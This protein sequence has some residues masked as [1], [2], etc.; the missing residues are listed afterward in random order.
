[1][2]RGRGER[3]REL[4]K[5]LKMGKRENAKGRG[6]QSSIDTTKR[7]QLEKK[8]ER[9]FNREKERKSE[10]ERERKKGRDKEKER[11]RELEGGRGRGVKKKDQGTVIN[12]DKRMEK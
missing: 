7:K 8:R 10:R 2:D 6:G 12:R 11:E 9:Q 4:Q 1:M 3:Q 5:G